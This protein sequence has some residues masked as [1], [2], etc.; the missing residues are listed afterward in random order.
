M[1]RCSVDRCS[2]DRCSVD[3]HYENGVIDVEHA[4]IFGSLESLFEIRATTGTGRHSYNLARLKLTAEGDGSQNDNVN[5]HYEHD[6]I[7]TGRA[8]FLGSFRRVSKRPTTTGAIG[9]IGRVGCTNL[10][11]PNV[12]PR[13]KVDPF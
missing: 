13:D 1:D 3:C 8:G 7:S 11:K 5:N 6:S 4:L 9:K 12:G 2:V 10:R